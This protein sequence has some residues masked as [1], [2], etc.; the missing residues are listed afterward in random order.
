MPSLGHERRVC[1]A[2]V[3]CFI[4][5]LKFRLNVTPRYQPVASGPA[6]R[7]L[8]ETLNMY[9]HAARR[10]VDVMMVLNGIGS[11]YAMA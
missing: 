2:C 7:M 4:H 3:L 11:V 5:P 9:S 10:G 8:F 6:L 1:H